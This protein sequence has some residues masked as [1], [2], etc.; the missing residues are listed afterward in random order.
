MKNW[1]AFI[2]LMLHINC[3]MFIAQVDEVDVF[4][5]CGKQVE[6][7]NSLVQYFANVLHVHRKSV[8][9]GDDDNA[10]YF[11]LE[12]INYTSDNNQVVELCRSVYE[13]VL[14][15]NYPPYLPKR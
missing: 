4:D 11:H 10:R 15:L 8:K 9:D 13:P 7:I 1:F 14:K 3:S 6:D 12:K 2:L 5:K